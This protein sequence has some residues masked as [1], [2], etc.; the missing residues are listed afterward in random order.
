VGASLPW[1]PAISA[2]ANINALKITAGK[3]ET[4]LRP[5]DGAALQAGRT[6][7]AI[8]DRNSSFFV[9]LFKLAQPAPDHNFAFSVIRV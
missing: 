5:D 8:P 6:S 1:S 4:A 2:K 7:S 3:S 9:Q